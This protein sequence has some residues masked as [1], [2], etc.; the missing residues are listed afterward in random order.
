MIVAVRQNNTTP[1]SHNSWKLDVTTSSKSW[2]GRAILKTK[3]LSLSANSS[4]IRPVLRSRYPSTIIKNTG[5]VALRLK[6]R[7]SVK[8][9]P[10]Q[11]SRPLSRPKSKKM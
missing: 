9:P 4:A 5:T 6:M 11:M 1:P 8:P 7:F 2:T 10:L 3:V